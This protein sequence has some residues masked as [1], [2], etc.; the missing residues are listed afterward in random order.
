MGESP[1]NVVVV[2]E[3]GKAMF[4]AAGEYVQVLRSRR[5]VRE[6]FEWNPD[7]VRDFSGI[8]PYPRPRRDREH[9]G[10]DCNLRSAGGGLHVVEAAEEHPGGVEVDPHLFV[11]LADRGLHLLLGA[12]PPPAGKGHVAGPGIAL[13]SG[14]LDQQDLEVM[15]CGAQQKRD[16]SAAEASA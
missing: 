10:C 6:V 3:C 13:R 8:G 4:I 15:R 9:E 11:G 1:D 2:S 12:G 14:P 7:G 16:G 5:G